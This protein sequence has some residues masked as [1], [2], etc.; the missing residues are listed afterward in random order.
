MR[1]QFA[2]DSYKVSRLL[3]TDWRIDHVIA[4]SSSSSSTDGAASSEPS[5]GTLIHVKMVV[6]TQPHLGTIDTSSSSSIAEGDRVK[7]CSF[8]MSA[9]KLDVLIYELSNAHTLLMNMQ[10]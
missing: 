7:G 9:E 1:A 10:N 8:E 6:D 4:S 5:S 2:E 3:Q